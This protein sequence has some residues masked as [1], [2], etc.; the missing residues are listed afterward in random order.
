MKVGAAFTVILALMV[1]R[2]A[3]AQSQ[4]P[5]TIHDTQCLLMAV[6]LAGND[7]PDAK[8]AGVAGTMFFGGKILG[9]QPTIDLPSVAKTEALKLDQQALAK[10]Q[11]QYGNE[12][13]AYAV[14]LQAVGKAM[15]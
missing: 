8:S 13:K 2:M 6:T 9:A 10:L 12:I 4:T 7:D 1:P 5:A 14:Q 15:P 3:L 11:V